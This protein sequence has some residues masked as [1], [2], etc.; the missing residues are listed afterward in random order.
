MTRDY[1]SRGFIGGAPTTSTLSGSIGTGDTTFSFATGGGTGFPTTNFWALLDGSTANAE[2]VLIGSRS[3]DNCTGV[4]RGVDGTT[5]K[6]H[7]N[8][9]IIHTGAAQDFTEANAIASALTT[10]G[11]IL[12]KGGTLSV[13]PQRLAVG[14]TNG[15][16]L[17]VDSAQAV[18]LKY[19]TLGVAPVVADTTARDALIPSPSSGQAIYLDTGASTEGPYWY[20]GSAWRLPWS[21][22]WGRIAGALATSNQ[23]SITTVVDLTSLTVTFTAVA[24][25]IYEITGEVTMASTIATDVVAVVIADGSNT[26][27][28]KRSA[29]IGIANVGASASA[30]VEVTP[31]AGSVT[32]KL[33]GLRDSGTGTVTAVALA[34]QPNLIRVKDIGPAAGAPA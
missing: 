17:T 1:Q 30:S 14:A 19:T 11:D 18:K 27:V 13:A 2:K 32:Y 6:T 15:Q 9:T 24:N 7:T 21:M 12:V 23:G 22:G 29:A 33:R 4:V 31:S 34:N 26:Q 10:A 3:G 28:Q 8:P 5:A 25:R 16:V 20:N